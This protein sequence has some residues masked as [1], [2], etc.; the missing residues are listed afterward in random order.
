[1]LVAMG[2]ATKWQV[3]CAIVDGYVAELGRA[4][5]PPAYSTVLCL[6]TSQ[7]LEL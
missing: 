4:D 3:L 1:M 2:P 7:R 6:I 5:R